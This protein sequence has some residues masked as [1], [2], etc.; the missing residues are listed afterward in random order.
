MATAIDN[1]ERPNSPALSGARNPSE[2][3]LAEIWAEVLR[4]PD[5]EK[6]ANFF[7]IGGD[8]L[9][10]MEVITRVREV[11]HIDLPLIA[12]FEDPTLAHLDAVVSELEEAE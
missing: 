1:Q 11:L 2:E 5:V 8:S 3:A 12:F 6:N 4:R 10:E 9:K 7:D